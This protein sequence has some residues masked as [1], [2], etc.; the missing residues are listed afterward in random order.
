[1]SISGQPMHRFIPTIY[2]LRVKYFA[3]HIRV[4]LPVTLNPL[5]TNVP[6][7]IN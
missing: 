2:G 4:N 3:K 7:Q 6:H 5:T 1:M